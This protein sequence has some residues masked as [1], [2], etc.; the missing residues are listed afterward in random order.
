MSDTEP[1]SNWRIAGYRGIW[2]TLTEFYGRGENGETY[3]KASRTPVFPYGD[4]YSGGL[5]TYTAKHTPLAVYRPEV[6]K[7]FFVYGGTTKSD[8]CHLLCMVSYYDHRTQTV[9]RPVVV[10]DKQGVN[11]PP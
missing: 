10:H 7:T 4:K 2:F 5:G 3:A 1:N 11:D 9:P 6:E 8:E